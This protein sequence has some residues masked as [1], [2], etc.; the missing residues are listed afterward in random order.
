MARRIAVALLVVVLTTLAAVPG[1]LAEDVPEARGI[2]RVCPPPE[3]QIVD[4]L[5]PLPDAGAAHGDAI[6]CATDYQIIEGF[7]D[8]TFRPGVPVTRGQVASL[9]ARWLRTATGIEL[10]EGTDTPF[11]DTEGTQHASAIH[12]LAEFELVSGR[13]D[14]TFG[15]GDPLTRG[16]LAQTVVRAISFADVLHIDGPLPPSSSEVSFTDVHEDTQ[17]ADHIHSLAG[18]GVVQGDT[19]GVYNP[20]EPVT[21]GQLA[22]FLMRAADYL[23][24]HQRFKPSADREVFSFRLRAQD[25]VL[26]DPDE[27]AEGGD[28]DQDVNGSDEDPTDP[29]GPPTPVSMTAVLIIDAFN[30]TL[31]Y[32]LHIGDLEGPFGDTA[33][34]TLHVGKEGEVGPLVLNLA[35][36][37]SLDG[38]R[39]GVATDVVHEADSILRFAEIVR[40]PADFYLQITTEQHPEGAVRGQLAPG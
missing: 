26:P 6:R 16:Q 25:V 21:R 33:G 23:D 28:A 40:S 19:A 12:A 14:G 3:D 37:R 10:P 29:E 34:A 4:G 7:E 13:L 15:P 20:G 36:G 5:P 9:V 27:D 39:N 2:E 30:G 31:A 11:S 35:G 1:V 32:T 24:V 18:I 8:E 22:T 38:A 17:F